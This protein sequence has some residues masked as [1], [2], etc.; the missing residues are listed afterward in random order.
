MN[1]NGETVVLT[2][3]VSFRDLFSAIRHENESLKKAGG[4]VS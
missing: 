1:F 4:G 3:V 2:L